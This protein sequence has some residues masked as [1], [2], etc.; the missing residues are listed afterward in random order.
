MY[1]ITK[2]DPNTDPPLTMGGKISKEST[3]EPMT[4]ERTAD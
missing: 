1:Y 4:L 2:Q 3:T